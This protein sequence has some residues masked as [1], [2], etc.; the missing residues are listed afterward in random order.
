MVKLQA[1]ETPMNAPDWTFARYRPLL[2]LYVRQIQLGKCLRRV[3][4]SSDVVQETFFR[5]LQ[6]LDKFRGKT[7]GELVAWLRVITRNHL[8]DLMGHIQP[9]LES[10]TPVDAFANSM[11]PGPSTMVVSGENVLLLAAAIDRLPDTQRDAIICHY[12]LELPIAEA[13]ARL[14]KNEKSVA[15]LV[16][17][18]KQRL[19]EILGRTG[20]GQ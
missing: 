4:D 18:G 1:K 12:L 7:E 17:R 10:N 2:H 5:A 9:E 16:F 13:A 8:I 6:G 20:C 19:K 15:M 11:I 3:F 14:K